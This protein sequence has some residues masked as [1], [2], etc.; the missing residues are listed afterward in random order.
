M[1]TLDAAAVD[2]RVNEGSLE[3]LPLYG[4]GGGDRGGG[5]GEGGDGGGQNGGGG[6]AGS[7]EG[8]DGRGG[9]GGDDGGGEAAGVGNGCA[10]LGLVDER[11]C[12]AYNVIFSDYLADIIYRRDDAHDDENK[13][14]V[15]EAVWAGPYARPLFRS[16]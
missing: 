16:T 4:S 12:W 11:F 7:G 9:A 2:A 1:V 5:G 15:A 3:C 14:G 6:G 13:G 8:G 10:R